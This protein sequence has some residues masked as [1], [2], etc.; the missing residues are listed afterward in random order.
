V[1]QINSGPDVSAANRNRSLGV[2]LG[3]PTTTTK[4]EEL[5]LE[6]E[7]LGQHRS[8]ATRTTQLCGRD[9][10]VKQGE[11]EVPYARV[12]VGRTPRPT[13]RC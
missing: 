10:E 6:H 4:G 2:G 7:I 11:Q 1:P 3:A 9:R 8:H 5:L 13:Q 12:S